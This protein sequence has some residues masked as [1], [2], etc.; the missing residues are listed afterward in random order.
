MK[1]RLIAILAF[2]FFFFCGLL[3]VALAFEWNYR[4]APILQPIAFSHPI[5]TSKLGL[6]CTYCH[7]NADKSSRAT[8]PAMKICMNCHDKAVTDRTEIQKL[9]TYWKR[10][11][12]VPWNR[13][14]QLPWHVYFTHKRHIKAGIDC[15]VCHG[16]VKTMDV[17]KQVRS[18]EM[19]W[20]VSCHRR[21]SA[22]TD[23]LTCH[24]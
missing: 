7:V 23:C 18:L 19:G 14:H 6:E 9:T 21:N 5:H 4:K 13:I 16:F 24:K 3:I 11:E 12:P 22:S 8:V 1:Q 15:S 17:V 2:G 10:K 20:C